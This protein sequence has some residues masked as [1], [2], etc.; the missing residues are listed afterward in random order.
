MK[1]K[2]SVPTQ[3]PSFRS[4]CGICDRPFYSGWPVVT[5]PF[6]KGE[7][8]MHQSCWDVV[9]EIFAGNP[10]VVIEVAL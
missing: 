6:P 10:E 4:N 9:R 7:M 8:R 1:Q 5:L 2:P 3:T